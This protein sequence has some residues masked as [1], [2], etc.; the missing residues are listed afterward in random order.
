[1]ATDEALEETSTSPG[2]MPRLRRVG[3]TLRENPPLLVGTSVVTIYVILAIVSLFVVGDPNAHVESG[4]H[5]PSLAH[6]FGTTWLGASV[7]TQFLA[8]VKWALLIALLSAMVAIVIG[9]NIGLVSGYMGGWVEESL[10]TITDMAMGLPVLPFGL[11]VAG[12]IGKSPIVVAIAVGAVLWRSIARVVRSE[13]KAA[14]ERPYVLAAE[15]RGASDVRIMY[16]HILPNLLNLISIYVPLAAAWGLLTVSGIAFLG[17][18]RTDLITWGLM[19]HNTWTSGMMI[20]APWWFVFPSFGIAS[21][22][23]SLFLISR[24]LEEMTNPRL[25]DD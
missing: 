16:R 19:I 8:S 23:V 6:P 24:Q 20:S 1:M 5:P 11:V 9:A 17:L 22:I 4:P 18:L 12:L 10:M 14:K 21:L 2:R 13:T 25:R 7:L 15:A 3:S